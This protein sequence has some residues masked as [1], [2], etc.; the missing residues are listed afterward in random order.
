MPQIHPQIPKLLGEALDSSGLQISWMGKHFKMQ[1][2]QELSEQHSRSTGGDHRRERWNDSQPK[3]EQN[4]CRMP[5][6][7]I[8]FR[9]F[10]E[11]KDVL[12]SS[13]PVPPSLCISLLFPA[14]SSASLVVTFR[15]D[16]REELRH[17]PFP[18]N[19]LAIQRGRPRGY[20][21]T[22]LIPSQFAPFSIC[23][24]HRI[25]QLSLLRG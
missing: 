16:G 23:G 9:M 12:H 15:K 5:D 20:C 7:R 2:E 6:E 4:L 14:T 17:P 10:K 19:F 1:P 3:S 13:R 11:L 24:G 25:S 21:L 22:L 8:I 18:I